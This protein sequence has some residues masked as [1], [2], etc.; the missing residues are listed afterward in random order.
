MQIE[1]VH[2]EGSKE[3]FQ[4]NKEKVLLGRSKKCDVQLHYPG[5]SREHL[6]IEVRDGLIFLT[7]KGST[8]GVFIDGNRM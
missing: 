1:V 5:I 6:L 3:L 2:G 7:D 4:I 8:N